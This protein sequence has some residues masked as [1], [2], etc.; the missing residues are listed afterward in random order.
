MHHQYGF[1]VSELTTL[2]S[3]ATVQDR[4]LPHITHPFETQTWD[5]YRPHFVTPQRLDQGLTFWQTYAPVLQSAAKQYGVPPEVI[6]ALLGVETNYGSN[7]GGFRTLDTLATLAFYYPP[8][9][10]FF[11]QE[12]TAFLL[13]ARETH[14]DPLSFNGSYAGAIGIPQFMPSSYRR[15][16]ATYPPRHMHANEGPNLMM[17]EDT[18]MSVAN[19]LHQC[20]WQTEEP[21]AHP[22][23]IAKAIPVTELSTARHMQYT[24]LSTLRTRGIYPYSRKHNANLRGTLIRLPLSAAKYEYWIAFPNFGVL[25]SYNTSPLYAM[26]VYQL[27]AALRYA[28]NG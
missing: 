27:S 8:R 1:S 22:A 6:V 17:V 24:A 5:I 7:T 23:W 2:F 25:L 16:A 12:L 18:I 26:A 21:I 13:M 14:H 11:R 20:G 15:F 10:T 4:V 3:K 19:Y 28:H 9:A